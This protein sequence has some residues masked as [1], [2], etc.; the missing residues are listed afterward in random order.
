MI[1]PAGLYFLLFVFT[2]SMLTFAQHRPPAG[3]SSGGRTTAPSGG[4]NPNFGNTGNNPG[5]MQRTVELRIRVA[6]QD[7]RAV[8]ENVQVQ[9]VSTSGATVAQYFTNGQ[10]E[11]TFAGLYPG[12]YMVKVSGGTVKDF[13]SDNFYLDRSQ[14]VHN[15]WLHVQAKEDKNN[16]VTSTQPTVAAADLNVPEKAQKEFNKGNDALAAGDIKKATE[17]YQKAIHIYP[18]Y[19]MAYNNLGA[20][21]M[22]TNDSE[23][24]REAFARA[25]EINPRLTSANANLARL[26]MQDKKFSD[27]IPLLDRALASAPTDGELLLLMADAQLESGHFDQAVSY[28]RK[29]HTG[30]HKKYT[31]AHLVAGRALESENK[32]DEARTEYE[33]FLKESSEP[34]EAQAAMARQ[35][36]ARLNASAQRNNNPT[37]H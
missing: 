34:T 3:T 27:A 22:H 17:K 30:E 32:P 10:G 6:Y 13:T 1:R 19:S 18:N 28:A 12:S 4:A 20:A 11:V 2:T 37:V 14:S 25:V 21:Y 35:A 15:E 9:L 8:G 33:L 29:L 26:Q 23:H 36:L 16:E 5:S 31:V 24:A 7:E